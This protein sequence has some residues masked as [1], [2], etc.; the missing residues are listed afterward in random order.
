MSTHAIARTSRY[1]ATPSHNTFLGD[2]TLVSYFV[3]KN[4]QQKNNLTG[5]EIIMLIKT[6]EPILPIRHERRTLVLKKMFERPTIPLRIM[7]SCATGL[8]GD[9]SCDCLGDMTRYLNEI[10]VMGEGVFVYLPQ[11][12]RGRGLRLKLM[13]H[14]LQKG[15]TEFGMATAPLDFDAALRAVIPNETF[16]IRKYA[17]VRDIFVDLGLDS[18]SFA[19]LGSVERARIFQSQTGLSLCVDDHELRF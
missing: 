16:D 8:L 11:E 14:Q 19:W 4:E 15:V 9:S 1:V 13:D 17:F 7:S 2:C 10:N 6:R 18:L 5:T 3:P 12:G